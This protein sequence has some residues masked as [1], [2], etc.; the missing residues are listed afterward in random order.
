MVL[1][2]ATAINILAVVVTAVIT[3]IAARNRCCKNRGAI[4][5]KCSKT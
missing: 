4:T 3:A 2:S 1:L 5:G